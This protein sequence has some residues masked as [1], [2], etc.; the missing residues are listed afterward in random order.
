MLNPCR[1]QQ[2]PASSTKGAAIMVIQPEP[3]SFHPRFRL[4]SGQALLDRWAST[5]GQVEKN[6]VYKALL[7]V[8]DGSVFR[9]HTIIDDRDRPQDFFVLAREDLVIK[10]RMRNF[11][12]F[13]ILYI[14]PL[15]GATPP[16][17]W[18]PRIHVRDAE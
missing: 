11:E 2:T 12:S 6:A 9:T 7:C 4:D 13:D 18:G 1:Q 16:G 15:S 14:G 3:T 17:R 10:I 8:P 5:A